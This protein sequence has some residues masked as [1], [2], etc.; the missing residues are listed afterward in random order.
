MTGILRHPLEGFG[1][2]LHHSK[3]QYHCAVRRYRSRSLFLSLFRHSLVRSPANSLDVGNLSRL[4]RCPLPAFVVSSTE[5]HKGQNDHVLAG[6]LF[7]F[8]RLGLCGPAQKLRNVPGLLGYG[9]LRSVLVLDA[10][11]GERGRHRNGSPWKVGIVVETGHHFLSGRWIT[12]SGQEGKDVIGTVVS[13]LDHETQIGRV[14]PT[15]R[16]ATGLLVGIGRRNHVVRFSGAL[17]HFSLVVGAVENVHVLRHLLYFLFRVGDPDQLAESNVVQRVARGADLTVYLV[18][19]AKSRVVERREVPLV[20]P[21]IV[22][23]V[24]NVFFVQQRH[25]DGGCRGQGC[26]GSR[27]SVFAE[28]CW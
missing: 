5:G 26:C 27:E 22:R 2:E 9:G 3:N 7:P 8:L 13:C 4:E 17:E 28:Q 1:L 24:D 15:V 21:R 25:R 20:P 6:I 18:A 11:I 19:P 10:S 14:R 12:V 16:G 23:W